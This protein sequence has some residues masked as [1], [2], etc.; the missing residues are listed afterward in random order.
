M[1]NFTDIEHA[2]VVFQRVRPET[3]EITR[4]E[5]MDSA[6]GEVGIVHLLGDVKNTIRHRTI[7]ILAHILFS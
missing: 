5:M 1:I 4:S 6:S 2:G 7:L 3:M